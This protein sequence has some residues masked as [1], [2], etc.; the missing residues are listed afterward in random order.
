ML[1]KRLRHYCQE[2]LSLLARTGRLE[3]IKRG[4][5][6]VTNRAAVA[7]YRQSVG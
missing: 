4:R 6:W 5:N 3:A 1:Q 7:A 2:Y